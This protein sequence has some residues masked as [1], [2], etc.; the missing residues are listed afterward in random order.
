MIGSPAV[1]LRLLSATTTLNADRYRDR[2]C[3]GDHNGQRDD[4]HQLPPFA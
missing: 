4:E 1:A 3:R 2:R